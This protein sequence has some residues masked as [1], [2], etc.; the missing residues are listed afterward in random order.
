MMRQ[1]LMLGTATCLSA[2]LLGGCSKTDSA[3]STA[4]ADNSTVEETKSVPLIHTIDG[5]GIQHV[6]LNMPGMT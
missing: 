5:E 2:V 1:F 3:D 4:S 6:K